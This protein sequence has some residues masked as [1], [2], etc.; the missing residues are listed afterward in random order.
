MKRIAKFRLSPIKLDNARYRFFPNLSAFSKEKAGKGRKGKRQSQLKR[1]P[2]KT[3]QS[4]E[5]SRKV[6]EAKQSHPLEKITE[7]MTRFDEICEFRFSDATLCKYL[8]QTMSSTFRLAI[9]KI[10]EGDS[11]LKLVDG[12]WFI[13][14]EISCIIDMFPYLS[15]VILNNYDIPHMYMS[16]LANG[17]KENSTITILSFIKTNTGDESANSLSDMLKHNHTVQA[18]YLNH[19][20]ISYVGTNSICEGIEGN[21]KS[22]LTMLN[23]RYNQIGTQNASNICERLKKTNPSITLYIQHNALSQMSSSHTGLLGD[24][25]PLVLDTDLPSSGT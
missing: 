11:E 17:L 12:N 4:G 24:I 15:T 3:R 1:I 5:N 9:L 16:Q 2:K 8:R 13:P 22:A 14:S 21:P 20:N 6:S 23:L 18:L 25:P 7:K 10:A 19:N